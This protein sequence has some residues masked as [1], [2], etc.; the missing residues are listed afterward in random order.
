MRDINSPST[1][2]Q[3]PRKLDITLT[4]KDVGL[5][6]KYGK[7]N[8][9]QGFIEQYKSKHPELSTED[10]IALGLMHITKSANDSAHNV[11][12]PLHNQI[13]NFV[14]KNNM[15]NGAPLVTLDQNNKNTII[16]SL[17]NC[18]CITE[19]L[20]YTYSVN[21]NDQIKK[22]VLNPEVRDKLASIL[23]YPNFETHPQSIINE[24]I[25][26]LYTQESVD[27][28]VEAVG[29]QGWLDSYFSM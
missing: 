6:E 14:Y 22:Y 13:L 12:S 29:G 9:L 11:Q 23:K 1:V 4:K 18:S 8:N 5:L 25:T 27:E 17:E 20:D 19:L 26:P 10:I 24:L 15:L 3:L 7:Q 16:Y 21:K 28:L 2:G